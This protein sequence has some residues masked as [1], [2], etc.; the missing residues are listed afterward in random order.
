MFREQPEGG[1]GKVPEMVTRWLSTQ[2][3]PTL[4]GTQ[5]CACFNEGAPVTS[6]SVAVSRSWTGQDGQRPGA[7]DLVPRIG[8]E[9]AG[10][11]L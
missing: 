3:N 5:R 2:S 4:A 8:L 9:P 11:E 7:R 1:V 10:G 6:F